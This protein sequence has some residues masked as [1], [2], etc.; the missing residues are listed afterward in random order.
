MTIGKLIE[1][2]ALKDAIHEIFNFIREAN[3]FFDTEQPW[4]TR[5][6]NEDVCKNTL[7]QCVQIIANLAVL[8]QPFL[9]FSSEKVCSWLNITNIWERKIVPAGYHLPEIE[10]LFQ[11][12]EKKAIEEESEKCNSSAF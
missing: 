1:K 6:T 4:I 2:A 9:P 3:K 11:R 12:I 8:L 10:I 7:Y 5:T